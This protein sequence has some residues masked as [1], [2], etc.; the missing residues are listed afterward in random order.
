M[1][2]IKKSSVNLKVFCWQVNNLIIVY[3]IVLIYE[4]ILNYILNTSFILLVQWLVGKVNACLLIKSY[5][6]GM[7]L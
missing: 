7:I 2:G 4:T 6:N 5:S 1:S 3:T